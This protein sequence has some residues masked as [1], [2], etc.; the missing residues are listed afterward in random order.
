MSSPLGNILGIGHIVV[1]AGAIIAPFTA[2]RAFQIVQTPSTVFVTR[3]F[4]SR[5]FALGA[6][7]QLY[8]RG[9]PENRLAVLA[10]GCIHGFDI[11]QA[12]VSFAQGYL[13]FEALI[14][15]GTVDTLLTAMCWLELST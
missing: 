1:G 2:A 6:G 15:A 4:G 9:T 10:C 11:L 12:I 3:A 7:I 13:P 14:V 8:G 5:D